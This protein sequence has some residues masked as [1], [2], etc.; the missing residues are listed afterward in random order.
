MTAAATFNYASHHML[1]DECAIRA[2]DLQNDSIN[3]YRLFNPFS[4]AAEDCEKKS[5]ATREFLINNRTVIR[6]GYGLTDSCVVDIDSKMRNGGEW[7][8]DR[9]KTQLYPRM[10]QAIPNLGRGPFIADEESKLIQSSD[11]GEKK[12][13]DILSEVQINRFIPL[14]PSLAATVQNPDNIVPQWVRGGEPSRDSIRHK[15]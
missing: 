6:D 9:E 1:S 15:K 3:D 12:S 13:C 8:N 14:I 10:Y 7:T 11:T 5:E 4:R 2:R